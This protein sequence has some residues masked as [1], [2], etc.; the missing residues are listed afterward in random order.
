[1]GTYDRRM[2]PEA[3]L[4]ATEAGLVP[5]GPG[6]FVVNARDARWIASPG[7]GHSLPLT[8]RDTQ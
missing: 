6:W 1:M 3:P 2:V 4:R 7:R 5:D 8:G